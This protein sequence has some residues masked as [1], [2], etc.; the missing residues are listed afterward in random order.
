[1]REQQKQKTMAKKK[2]LPQPGIEPGLARPQRAVLPLHHCGDVL[3]PGATNYIFKQTGKMEI[4]TF[5]G[6]SSNKKRTTHTCLF[7][8]E[9]HPHHLVVGRQRA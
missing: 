5:V 4:R 8:G 3:A 6:F 9:L 7:N 1:M 2:E